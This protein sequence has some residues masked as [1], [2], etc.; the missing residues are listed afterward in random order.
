MK[1]KNLILKLGILLVVAMLFIPKI[2]DAQTPKFRIMLTIVDSIFT[3]DTTYRKAYHDTAIFAFHPNASACSDDITL[4]GYTDRWSESFQGAP[5]DSSMLE[6][7]TPPPAP[8]FSFFMQNTFNPTPSCRLTYFNL[9]LPYISAAQSDSFRIKLA[10]DDDAAIRFNRFTIKWPKVLSEYLTSAVMRLKWTLAGVPSYDIIDMTKDSSFSFTFDS[11]LGYTFPIITLITTGPKV[12]PGLPAA[13]LAIA[14]PIGDISQKDTVTI[15]WSSTSNAY[16]YR[17]QVSKD[18]TFK[19][20]IIKDTTFNGTFYKLSKLAQLT[21]HYWR[22]SVQNAYGLSYYPNPPYKFRTGPFSPPSPKLMYPDSVGTNI[23]LTPTFRWHTS[24]SLS[25]V[26][27]RIQISSMSNFSSIL[28]DSTTTD[29]VMAVS[30][31]FINC[32][33]YYWRVN[34][35]DVNGPSEYS[36]IWPFRAAYNTPAIPVLQSPNDAATNVSLTPTLSWTGDV[37]TE[38]YHLQVAKDAGFA[39]TVYDNASLSQLSQLLPALEQDMIYY[40][41]VKSKNPIDSSEYTTARTF[42]TILNPA[43]IPVYV[44]PASGDTSRNPIDILRW[45]KVP[46]AANYHVQVSLNQS[47]TPLIAEDSTLTDTSFTTPSLNNCVTYYWKVRAINRNGSAGFTTA[48]NFK[49]K[50]AVA[51][52][53]I[54][55]SP[56]NGKDSLVENVT[57]QWHAGDPCTNSYYFHVSRNSSFTDTVM[58][59]RTSA[60]TYNLTGL[61][62]NVYYY[63]HVRAVNYLGEGAYS[64]TFQFHTT[65]SKPLVPALLEPVNDLGDVSNCLTFKWDSATF[66]SFYRLQVARDSNFTNLFFND[67]LIAKQ[68]GVRPSKEVCGLP[69]AI[70][71]YWRVNAKNE[72]GTGDWSVVRKFTTLYPPSDI[73]LN[74]PING[75]QD[76]S[77]TPT[78]D[79]SIALRATAYQLQVAEDTFMVKKVYDDTTIVIESWQ[80][81]NSL[82]PNTKYYWRV[83]GKNSAGWGNW[84]SIYSF[85]T[86]RVGVANWLIPLTIAETGPER[87]TIYFGLR[88]EATKGIDPAL[89]EFELPPIQY[90][91]FDARMVS[92]YIGEGLLVEYHKFSSYSQRDTFQFRFQPGMGA[93]PMTIS[94]YK[95]RVKDV[96]DSMIV[97]DRLVSPTLRARMDIDSFLVVNNSTIQNLYI[98]SYAAYPFVDVKPIEIIIPKGFVLYQNY[99][100]PFNPSTKIH[101]TTDKESRITLTIFDILG[102]EIMVLAK[103]NYFAG[104]YTFEWNG[105][106]AEGAQMPSGVY[107]VRMIATPVDASESGTQPFIA[108]QKMIMMK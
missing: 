33:S 81:L 12:P 23:P 21:W 60:T 82:D 35:T 3:A 89:G 75:E 36:T 80:I 93:Y 4:T 13:P 73:I 39:Q 37:C 48:R 63:W 107:Y 95:A 42:T 66:A 87:Q 40:W 29:T 18:S 68:S 62:G 57:L 38:T 49:I 30:G 27:Y 16:H 99:P 105:K 88:P 43:A 108:T 92:P 7:E 9:T 97:T 78:F 65:K 15:Q 71:M 100:N 90:G 47:F 59:G 64:E 44:S 54:L 10:R 17:L 45:R 83:R 24:A 94:W 70:R 69:N 5:Y 53:P 28:K 11:E 25:P 50:T 67:S 72:I 56:V 22:V 31:I 51:G 74:S 96:C 19:T 2:A 84:T 61:A 79:W 8:G 85:T 76:V 26:T 98:I 106:N 41:R 86:T 55:D 46:Y 77:R 52:A 102:R 20:N 6:Q 101:F 14:P 34:A 103:S 32:N 104:G 1:T 58:N 91:Y